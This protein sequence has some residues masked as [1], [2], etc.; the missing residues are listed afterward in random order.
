M[1]KSNNVKKYRKQA[2]LSQAALATQI[3]VTRQT[4]NLIENGKYNPTLEILIKLAKV[5]N[6]DLNALFWMGETEM[7]TTEI[8]KETVMTNEIPHAVKAKFMPN[9]HLEIEFDNNETRYFKI[10]LDDDINTKWGI[11]NSFGIPWDSMKCVIN[12]DGS[13]DVNNGWKIIGATDLW[14]NSKKHNY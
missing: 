2:K 8:K 11:G 13:V 5:L 7:N 6:T 10:P 12:E 14:E 3:G 4:I 9:Y 1:S